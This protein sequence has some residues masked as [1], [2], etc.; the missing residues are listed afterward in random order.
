MTARLGHV[1]FWTCLCAGLAMSLPQV[2]AEIFFGNFGAA[3]VRFIAYVG[4]GFIVGYAL[5][6]ALTGIKDPFHYTRKL[7]SRF[8]RE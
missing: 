7:V 8:S 1:L 4:V 5:R 3:A 6:F 2:A